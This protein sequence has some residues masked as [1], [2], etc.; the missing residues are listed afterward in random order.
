M[1]KNIAESSLYITDL[2]NIFNLN[3]DIS[4]LS[5]STFLITGAS[6]LIGSCLVDLLMLIG[7]KV[8]AVGRSKDAIKKRFDNY[9]EKDNFRFIECDVVGNRLEITENI[10]YIIHAASNANPR[11]F[12]EDPVGTMNANYI[13]TYNLLEFARCN[14][15][16]RFLYVSSGEIYG[17]ADIDFFSE[18]DLGEVSLLKSRSCYPISKRA[19]ETLCI[20]YSEQFNIETVIARPCHIYGPTFTEKDNR[21]L[22]EF[23]RLGLNGEDIILKSSGKQRRSHCYVVDAVFALLYIL[24]L[25]NNKDA[26]NISSL[27]DSATIKEIAE[28]ISEFTGVKVITNNNED[29]GRMNA[30]LGDEKLRGLGWEPRYELKAGLQRTLNILKEIKTL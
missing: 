5:S 16:K 9:F 26:Y 8:I 10:D 4:K 17:E 3:L 30:V 18:D 1:A 25:G 27:R 11:A 15:I 6:G 19:G 28:S 7:A 2:K 22:A 23:I 20:S 13:G 21:V 14:N 29:S 12:S 24:L